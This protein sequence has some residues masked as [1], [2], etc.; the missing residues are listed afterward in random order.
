M[1][2]EQKA[3]IRRGIIFL[4]VIGTM[5]IILLSFPPNERIQRILDDPWLALFQAIT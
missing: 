1:D 5:V 2:A 4:A 3:S